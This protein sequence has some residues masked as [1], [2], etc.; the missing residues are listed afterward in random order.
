MIRRPPRSTL[1]PYTTLFRSSANGRY[2]HA[3]L[4][5]CGSV[6]FVC[7]RGWCYMTDCDLFEVN[8]R[9]EAA[10]WHDGSRDP[11]MKFVLRHCRFDG[12]EGWRFARH[13]HDAMIFVLDSTFSKTL[14]D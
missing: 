12:V 14:R 13:H 8:P 3:R 9:A 2:Y 10:M 5:V 6:D 11:D 7:P 4:K 1:F